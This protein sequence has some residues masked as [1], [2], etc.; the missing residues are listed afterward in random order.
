[1]TNDNE[2]KTSEVV[3]ALEKAKDFVKGAT[4][5]SA[6]KILFAKNLKNWKKR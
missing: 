2:T 6:G 3:P 1:M 5:Y 4:H